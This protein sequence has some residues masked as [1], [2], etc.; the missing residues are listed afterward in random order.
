MSN[1][2]FSTLNDKE[3]E[4]IAR[5]LLN[6]KFLFGL[7][8]F[9][10]GKD[11]GIDLRYSS[12]R[13]NNSIV[14]QCKHYIT[15]DFTDLKSK[16]KVEELPKVHMLA[17][18]RYIIATSL[19]LSAA[20][21]DDLK[22]VLSPY[23]LTSNDV[24][25]RDDINGLLSENNE[26]EKR[27]F[28]LW[29]SSVAVFEAIL[30]NAIEGRSRYLLEKINRK[31]P[32]YVMTSKFDDA[33]KILKKEKLLL[34]TG[35]PGIGKTTLAET[36]VFDKAKNGYKIYQVENITEAEEVLARN[37]D[38]KQLFYFD[39]FLGGNYLEIINAHR[40]ETQ[41]TSF[42]DRVK[43]APN[44]LLILTTR[45]VILNHALEKHEKINL[46]KIGNHQFEI[47]LTDYTMYEKAL[48]L[49]NHLYFN[50]VSPQH[51][52][53]IINEKF[54]RTIIE[55]KNYTP[56]II[57][58]ITD[59][60]KVNLF[61]AADYHQFII[62]NL[63]NP[64]EIWRFSYNNQIGYLDRC[65]LLTLFSFENGGTE[66]LLIQAFD[67]RLTYE[68]NEHN[69]VITSNQFE[70]SIKILMNGFV[71]STLLQIS[72]P[73]RQYTFINPSLGDFL[74]NQV[75]E[76][77]PERKSIIS[78]LIFVEQLERFNPE[79]SVVP[80]ERD[81]QVIIRDKIGNRQLQIRHSSG[82]KRIGIRNAA[83]YLQ[84]LCK[85]CRDINTDSLLHMFFKE[86]SLDVNWYPISHEIEY[87]LNHVGD[88]PLTVQ[89][90]KDNFL[91][92]IE[93]YM[94][95]IISYYRANKIRSLFDRFGH[96][97]AEYAKSEDGRDNLVTLIKDIL[98][99]E[100]RDIEERENEFTDFEEVSN[101]YD[102]VSSTEELLKGE[103]FSYDLID[104]DL[105]IEF[106]E[107]YW[108]KKV[109][110]NSRRIDGESAA[111]EDYDDEYF[112]DSQLD[113]LTQ[114]KSIDDLFSRPE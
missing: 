42:V 81:L 44:K 98:R 56:R 103:F 48:I 60:S 2:T 46:S 36:L 97:F 79:K 14:V 24:L 84:A 77:Y 108:Q 85:Y 10:S 66:Q 73:I 114:E 91:S 57:E 16:L 59:K 110:E 112:R 58:F 69:Q 71:L 105:S 53:S 95:T 111:Q 62:N 17:P 65:L 64:K 21:K 63:T 49:Y 109:D 38:E 3:F 94:S 31:I 27:Y 4:Q 8:S 41:L 28:K 88:S 23:I 55:H 92:I 12:P 52:D 34:I 90:I 37:D 39:D 102:D 19:P 93:K 7:Q 61:S 18:D 99:T 29:F 78:S 106:D 9:K 13:N 83:T 26:I 107:F 45:T 54:Y 30:H 104:E 5:D 51:Y 72:P 75:G 35:Q 100:E 50:Q 96:D 11:K 82:T 101:L 22:T 68:K 87:F 47:K 74:I 25:G 76:S 6:A 86:I 40:T 80:L 32:F 43:F 15:S 113:R 20:Q 33:N 70:D 67:E 1:Y 89:Y